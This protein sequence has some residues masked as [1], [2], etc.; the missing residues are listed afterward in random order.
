MRQLTEEQKAKSEARRAKFSALWKQISNMGD[1]EKAAFVAKF[2]FVTCE[3]RELSIHNQCLLALQCPEGTVFGGFRQWLKQGRAVRKG[4][5]GHMIWV[6]TMDRKGN[7]APA[8][9]ASAD[10]LADDTGSPAKHS[11]RFIIG[12]V[13]D[14]SQTDEIQTQATEVN[15][16]EPESVLA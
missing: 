13:F 10:I 8:Q 6:P 16:S 1:T 11:R 15:A 4:E 14:V 3:G 12:T 5:H 2:G 7:G 9:P